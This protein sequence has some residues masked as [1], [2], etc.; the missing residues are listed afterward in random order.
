M[1]PNRWDVV[2]VE[3]YD[4]IVESGNSDGS[5]YLKDFKPCIRRTLGYWLG[6]RIDY[7]FVCETDDRDAQTQPDDVERINAIYRPMIKSIKLFAKGKVITLDD[8]EE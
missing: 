5:K 6:E 2:E 3:W 8:E 1:I 7:V 4:A